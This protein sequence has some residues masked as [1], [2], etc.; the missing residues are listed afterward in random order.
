VASAAGSKIL[1]VP[2]VDPAGVV[3]GNIV[4]KAVAPLVVLFQFIQTVVNDV[5][6]LRYAVI[7]ILF[8]INGF[9]VFM[10]EDA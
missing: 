3:M 8:I 6:V 10:E 1:G 4:T 2:Q 5:L 7:E 9:A